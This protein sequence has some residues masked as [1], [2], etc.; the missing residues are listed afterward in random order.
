MKRSFTLIELLVVIAIIAILAGMLLPALGKAREAA[1]A[2]NCLSNLKNLGASLT[3]YANANDGMIVTYTDL[4]YDPTDSIA[5]LYWS[6]FLIRSGLLDE[7]SSVLTC[8]SVSSSLDKNE[9]SAARYLPTYG[10]VDIYAF[11]KD[12]LINSLT[13]ET[14]KSTYAIS[15]NAIDNSASF[16]VLGDSFLDRQNVTNKQWCRITLDGNYQGAFQTRHSEKA[17][18]SFAD[19]HAGS[20]RAQEIVNYMDEAGEMA[21]GKLPHIVD[22]DGETV[23]VKQP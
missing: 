2:S 23:E 16:I 8:P 5:Q 22:A 12:S 11:N 21:S 14:N 7:N 1:R 18:L 6:T 17:H 19:A 4:K 9:N 13:G 10:I 3:Q 15:T 20:G